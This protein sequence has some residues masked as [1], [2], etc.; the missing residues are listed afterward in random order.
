[1]PTD[2]LAALRA[3]IIADFTA[4][5][6][7]K[8]FTNLAYEFAAVHAA[9]L[10][11]TRK[12]EVSYSDF[13]HSVG[14]ANKILGPSE[15]ATEFERCEKGCF[16][17]LVFEQQVAAFESAFFDLARFLLLDRPD[18]L[19]SN[20][21][22]EYS[23]VV[24]AS[25]REEAIAELVDRET[26]T[27]KYQTVVKWFEWISSQVSAAS[28]APTT[29]QQIAEIKATRDILVHNNGVA[30]RAYLK[31]TGSAARFSDGARVNVNEPYHLQSWQTL[32]STMIALLDAS[33]GALSETPSGG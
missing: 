9:T 4:I 28:I 27:L 21:Q 29:I 22:V 18:R 25:S 6:E 23:V 33:I 19:P 14:L 26:N 12:F 30:N 7:F 17:E 31:K 11:G 13:A 5:M 3:R 2:K 16:L 8:A 24:G 15:L 20:K 32:L 10:P 1:M